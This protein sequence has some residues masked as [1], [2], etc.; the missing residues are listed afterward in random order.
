MNL[1]NKALKQKTKKYSL[2]LIKL[3][4]KVYSKFTNLKYLV[5]E[6]QIITVQYFRCL[7]PSATALFD[8]AFGN[9][10]YAS[11]AINVFDTFQQV[12]AHFNRDKDS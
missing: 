1:H 11:F 9:E 7:P 5:F 3:N 12:E 6:F 10:L 8:L 2:Q 4:C